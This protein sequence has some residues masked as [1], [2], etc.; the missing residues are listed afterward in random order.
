MSHLLEVADL[1]YSYGERTVLDGISFEAEEN[2]VVSILGP[3]GVGK[4]TMLRCICGFN[5][6][7]SGSVRVCGEDVGSMSG[8]TMAKNI[9]YVPQKAMATHTTVFDSVLIGRRPHMEWFAGRDDLDK[10]WEVMR[11][12]GVDGHSLDYVDQISG[13]EF[14]K[15]QIARAMVQEPR[16]LVMD[17]PTNNL[18]IANQHIAMHTIIDAACSRGLCTVMTMHDINLAVHYSDRLLFVK[19]GRVEA[20]GGT[21]IVTEDLIRRVYGIESD[22]IEHKGIPFV[23]PHTRPRD[24]SYGHSHAHS[25]SHPHDAYDH[26]HEAFG[27][28]GGHAHPHVHGDHHDEHE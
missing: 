21:E 11:M 12:L 23:I 18:D 27:D 14:Q 4:T 10:T 28:A 22:V 13:G 8:R 5:K 25:H 15:V 6:C 19:D 1:K 26:L 16:I 3:N 17:E 9:A 20:Y 24:V 2:Q 7:Q